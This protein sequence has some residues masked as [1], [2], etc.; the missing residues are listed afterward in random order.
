MHHRLGHSALA[1]EATREAVR[2]AQQSGDEECVAY[3]S[4]WSSL[5]RSLPGVAGGGRRGR[6]GV[7]GRAE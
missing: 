4:A 1:L 5:L 7:R 3:A 2:V 6:P